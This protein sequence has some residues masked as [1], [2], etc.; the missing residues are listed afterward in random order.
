MPNL[1]YG[2]P[3]TSYGMGTPYNDVGIN[4]N[5]GWFDDVISDIESGLGIVDTAVDLW[6]R[7]TGKD[8]SSSTRDTVVNTGGEIVSAGIGDFFKDNWLAGLVIVILAG[9]GLFFVIKA[10]K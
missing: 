5:D 4:Q 6:D 7:L 10:A 1:G 9:G 2:T 8:T 3:S